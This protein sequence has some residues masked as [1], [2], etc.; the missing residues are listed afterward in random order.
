M[1][2]LK[3]CEFFTPGFFYKKRRQFLAREVVEERTLTAVEP[4]YVA[5]DLNLLNCR[6][7][8]HGIVLDNTKLVDAVLL[9][10]RPNFLHAYNTIAGVSVSP[11]LILESS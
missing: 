7:C 6:L 1:L 2:L 5:V 4:E 10:N 3:V 9:R 11:E 8:P